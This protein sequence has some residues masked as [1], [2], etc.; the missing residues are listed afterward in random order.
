MFQNP[1]DLN[2]ADR[3]IFVDDNP[4]QRYSQYNCYD[5]AE[6]TGAIS[7]STGTAGIVKTGPGELELIGANTYNGTTTVLAGTLTFG[8]NVAAIPAA[9][10]LSP[11]ALS[12]L[13]HSSRRSARSNST[14]EP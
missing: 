12:T 2:G 13:A 4:K 3:T 8:N 9:P 1:I 14:A 7:N 6:M 5:H 10:T 11:A